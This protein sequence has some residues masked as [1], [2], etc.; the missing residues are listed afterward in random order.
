MSKFFITHSRIKVY[1]DDVYSFKLS[2]DDI[3]HHL[4]KIQRFGGALPL[5]IFYSVAEHSILMAKYAYRKYGKEI[6]RAALM[7]DAAEAYLGD[8]I[9]PLKE[10][11]L[12][13][14]KKEMMLERRIMDQYQINMYRNDIFFLIKELDRSILLDE[15][16][17]LMPT[18]YDI[19]KSVTSPGI[20]PLGLKIVP[21]PNQIAVKKAFLSWCNKL[22]INDERDYT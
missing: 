12:D 16:K 22:G 1:P 3:G 20:R 8:V 19:F 10:T 2:L 7:H 17:S 9:S 13:F 5:N 21:E 11:L 14:T 6:A 15:V 18:N 4:C